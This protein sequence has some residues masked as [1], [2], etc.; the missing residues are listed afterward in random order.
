MRPKVQE[1][2]RGRVE[3][4]QPIRTGHIDSAGPKSVCRQTTY[5]P[6]RIGG[7]SK[8]R[9]GK[10]MKDLLPPLPFWD[11]DQVICPHDPD[12]TCP[13]IGLGQRSHSVG[14]EACLQPLLDCRH[15]DPWVG[16]DLARP[17]YPNGEGRHPIARF[18]G[19]LRRNQPPNAIEAETL[20]RFQAYI[21]VAV[22]GWVERPTKQADPATG[23]RPVCPGAGHSLP[24]DG[25]I[26][27]RIGGQGR[28][29]PV[30]RTR[31]L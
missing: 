29:W 2:P 9:N 5:R 15:Q 12:K 19:V 16:S 7:A 30:P 25:L 1:A 11:L 20:Q 10:R 21:A 3:I 28:T 22:M 31:Y 4:G 13:G 14:G 24:N 17:R 27:W 18:E 8:D 23:D 26:G 6:K